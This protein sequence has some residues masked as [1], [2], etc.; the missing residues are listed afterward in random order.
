MQ[1]KCGFLLT[2][3]VVVSSVKD[4]TNEAE[5][6]LESQ[7]SM[8]PLKAQAQGNPGKKTVTYTFRLLDE[9]NITEDKVMK[10]TLVQTVLQ[11]LQT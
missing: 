5:E 2:Q 4:Q 3:L 10:E 7:E 11:M 6:R 1:Y 9:S 8:D